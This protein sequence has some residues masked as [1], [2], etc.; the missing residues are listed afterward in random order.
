MGVSLLCYECF[1][2]VGV[3][4]GRVGLGSNDSNINRQLLHTVIPDLTNIIGIF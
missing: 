4:E 3:S 2:C 1:L